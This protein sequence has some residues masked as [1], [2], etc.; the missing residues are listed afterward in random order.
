LKDPIPNNYSNFYKYGK[1]QVD[2]NNILKNKKS[3]PIAPDAFIPNS[4]FRTI[5]KRKEIKPI[6]VK[7]FQLRLDILKNLKKLE[8]FFRL[9]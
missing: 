6:E 8:D 7:A 1:G 5:F 4:S 9:E 2:I 3:Y